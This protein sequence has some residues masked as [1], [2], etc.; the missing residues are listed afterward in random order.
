MYTF[1]RWMAKTGP[2]SYAY[3][4]SGVTDALLLNRINHCRR[5][6]M[7]QQDA[8]A[9]TTTLVRNAP[10]KNVKRDSSAAAA[11]TGKHQVL[12]VP[13][14]FIILRS[15]RYVFRKNC[16]HNWNKTG[17]ETERTSANV[18]YC[19]SGT[20]G[21]C[22]IC[23]GQTLRVHIPDGSTFI[24]EMASWPPSWKYDVTSEILLSQSMR[25]YVKNNP[26]CQISSRSD[27]KRRSLRLFWRWSPQQQHKNYKIGLSSDVG[28]LSD[29]IIRWPIPAYSYFIAVYLHIS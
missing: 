10:V 3:H 24:R 6:A 21:S 7:N 12:L 20:G 5:W 4:G 1:R 29:P 23:I 19:E 13:I 26:A 27:L 16:L 9:A 14:W 25:I 17:K 22:C 11:A 2:I 28:S 15:W 8:V 18:G